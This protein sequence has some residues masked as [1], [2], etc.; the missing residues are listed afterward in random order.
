[1]TTYVRRECWD[2]AGGWGGGGEA[3]I[4]EG[5]NKEKEG[6]EKGGEEPIPLSKGGR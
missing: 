4:K 3:E 2:G 1:M 5:E 6:R